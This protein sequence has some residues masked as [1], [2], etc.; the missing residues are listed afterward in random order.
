MFEILGMSGEEERVY[1]HVVGSAD[2][3]AATVARELQM[4]PRKVRRIFTSLIERGLAARGPASEL[5]PHPPDI[6]LEAL[7]HRRREQLERLRL[8]LRS[9][10]SDYRRHSGGRHDWATVDP[11]DRDD[12]FVQTCLQGHV[13]ARNEIATIRR[14]NPADAI[15][16]AEVAALERGVRYRALY[17]IEEWFSLDRLEV[18]ERVKTGGEE[19]R[20]ATAVGF[21]LLL[22]DQRMA[23]VRFD[24]RERSGAF[25]FFAREGPIVDARSAHFELVWRTGSAPLSEPDDDAGLQDD[26]R[27]VTLLASGLTD[28]AV[29][30]ALGL[31]PRTVQ[32]RVSRVMAMLDARSRFEAGAEAVRRGWIG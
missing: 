21:E 26:R 23:V 28:D 25:G 2:R 19:S 29:G 12:A 15:F 17:P 3:T 11:L 16:D 1:L 18:F 22:V 30:R 14:G 10:D 5:V 9:L 13:L 7:I 27:L 8:D 20:S 31:A 24:P 4:S 32:R 6:A